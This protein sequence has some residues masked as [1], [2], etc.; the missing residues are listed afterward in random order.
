MKK[1]EKWEHPKLKEDA[2]YAKLAVPGLVVDKLLQLWLHRKQFNDTAW[3]SENFDIIWS[4][5]QQEKQPKWLS[6]QESNAARRETTQ[7]L[8]TAVRMLNE[9]RLDQYDLL[10]QPSFFEQIMPEFSVAGAADLIA[11]EKMS[12]DALLIDFK[13]AHRR[14]RIT[15]DQLLFYQIGLRP[16]SSFKIVKA[17]YLLYNPRLEEWKWFCLTEEHEERLVEKLIIATSEVLERKFDYRWNRFSCVRFCD[18]RFS[19]EMFQRLMYGGTRRK[20]QF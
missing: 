13:N 6:S 7:G 10:I 20:S 2:Q 3:L 11:I 5:V 8:E 1:L 15:K 19:C 16:R 14:E 18:V 4:M 17:G 9:L 12:R